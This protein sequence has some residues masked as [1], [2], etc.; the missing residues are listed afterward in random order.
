MIFSL[1]TFGSVEKETRQ[2]KRKKIRPEN[3]GPREWK[4]WGPLHSFHTVNLKYL[5]LKPQLMVLHI[6][7]CEVAFEWRCFIHRDVIVEGGKKK[8]ARLP[9]SGDLLSGLLLVVVVGYLVPLLST[10]RVVGHYVFN[11]TRPFFS[12]FGFCSNSVTKSKS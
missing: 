6:S 4:R 5:R 3:V 8:P 10:V 2:R 12:P 7:P 1:C 9:P 11:D